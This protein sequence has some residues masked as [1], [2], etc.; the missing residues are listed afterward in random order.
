MRLT[1]YLKRIDFEGPV[2]ADLETLNA[3]HEA[4]VRAVPFENLDVHAQRPVTLSVEAAY[5]QIVE[6][7]QGGWCY[8]MN[9][10]F[11]WV[12]SEIGFDVTRL[13]GGV[14]RESL[15]D[16][17]LGNHLCL[18]VRLDADYLVDVGFGGSQIAAIPLEHGETL[19][20]PLRMALVPIE[21]GFWRLHEGGWGSAMSYDFRPEAG[22]EALLAARH[23]EQI[24]DPNSIFR[25]TLVAKIR[26]GKAYYTL[27]GRML[28][29]NWPGRK[30][31]REIESAVKLAGVLKDLFG[32]EEP[33]LAELWPMIC[34]R[35]KQ[36]FP[37][38]SR[39]EA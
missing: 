30:E 37:H 32:L 25:K 29:T 4:H 21:G 16:V 13:A 20:R 1:D 38:A 2:K 23:E 17:A 18:M 31:T 39:G 34:A 24:T 7:R 8:E 26:R 15:G 36:V 5:E 35:H 6:Q 27:R 9:G 14:R 10:L 11:G 22:D 33:Q 28:E 3:L 12:L 19:H